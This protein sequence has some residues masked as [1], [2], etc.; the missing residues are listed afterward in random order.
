MRKIGTT[1]TGN[2]IIEMTPDE[3]NKIKDGATPIEIENVWKRNFHANIVKFNLHPTTRGTLFRNA[4]IQPSAKRFNAAE[5]R[6]DA[7]IFAKD[8]EL[9]N[10]RQ[11]CKM[12]A[13]GQIDVGKMR[14]FGEVR[15]V[16]LI[17]AIERHFAQS[18]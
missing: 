3:W 4:G 17:A 16:E 9:L 5:V 18:E 14:M 6:P 1:D 15:K 2:F 7:R 8:G 10:F 12:V 11:W 13:S